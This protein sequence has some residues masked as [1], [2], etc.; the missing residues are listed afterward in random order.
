MWQIQSAKAH[1]SELIEQA[2]RDGPQIITRHG[3]ER[4]VVLSIDDYR[5]L[6]KR[7]EDFKALLLSGPKL[8][9]FRI[10]RD[11]DTGRPVDL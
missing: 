2:E 6:M 9:D 8:D 7:G 4:A 3:V 5:L 10:E 1:L 11:A